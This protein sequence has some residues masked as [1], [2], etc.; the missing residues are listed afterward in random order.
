M[1]Q[2]TPADEPGHGRSTSGADYAQ[3]LRR[4]DES[5]WRRVLNVQAPYRWNIRRLHLGRTLDVGCGLGRNLV[6]LDGNGVGV[7]HNAESIR[8]ARER[9]LTAFTPDEFLASDE[10]RPESF[11]SIILAHVVEHLS[12]SFAS[13]L[14]SDYLPYLKPGGLV[15]LITPQERGY[16]SDA[17]HVTFTDFDKL[18]ALCAQLGLAE[19]RHYSFPFPRAVGKLFTYNEFVMVAKK[20]T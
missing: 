6:H 15:C 16:A 14:L 2:P 8:I 19:V 17:T 13:E 9:G 10:C 18:A 20:S 5:R 1:A 4:L 12:E 3:R 11:D 7:D